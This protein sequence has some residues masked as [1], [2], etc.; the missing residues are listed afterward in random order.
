MVVARDGTNGVPVSIVAPAASLL[1]GEM[2]E[3]IYAP[4]FLGL[5]TALTIVSFTKQG[6]L[7]DGCE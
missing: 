4:A 2:L 1:R 7:K 6:G 3:V 5:R